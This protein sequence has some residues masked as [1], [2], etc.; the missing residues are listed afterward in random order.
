[1]N[2]GKRYLQR[3][4]GLEAFFPGLLAYSGDIARAKP[5]QESN[6]FMW[7]RN[8]IEP[9]AYNYA[10][11]TILYNGYPL[12]PEIM[13]SA[14]YLYTLTGDTIYQHQ[15]RVIFE[16]LK[17]YCRTEH[18]YAELENVITKEQSDMMESFFLAETL[19]YLYLLFAPQGTID[20]K[21][22]VFN[23]EAHPIKKT[24]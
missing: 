4:G 5:I 3:W 19:K 9:E 17:K 10:A 21:T 2:T 15:G 14:Y 18:G 13:E 1:M 22:T 7:T 20:L 12:R 11:D 16:S 24:W 8:G 6:F 23:T